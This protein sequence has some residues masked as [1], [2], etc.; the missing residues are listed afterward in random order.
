MMIERKLEHLN[1]GLLFSLDERLFKRM[2]GCLF[3]GNDFIF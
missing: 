2:A 1:L 3:I